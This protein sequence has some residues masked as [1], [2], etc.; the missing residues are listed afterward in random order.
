MSCATVCPDIGID[1]NRAQAALWQEQVPYD[2]ASSTTD[3]MSET[4]KIT[5]VCCSSRNN[6]STTNVNVIRFIRVQSQ[7]FES[8]ET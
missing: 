2:V 5:V 3:R 1:E 7:L 8:T 6:Y 4:L